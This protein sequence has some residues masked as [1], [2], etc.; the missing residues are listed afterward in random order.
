MK[1]LFFGDIHGIDTNLNVIERKIE[2]EHIDKLVSLGDLYYQGPTP[3]KNYDVNSKKVLEFLNK[4]KDKLI[5]MKGNC[6]SSVDIKVSDFPILDT[7]SLINVDNLDIYIT[8]GDIYNYEKNNFNYKG[9]LVHAHK[10]I[11]YIRQEKDTTYICVGSI[12]LPRE[13]NNPTYA[14]YSNKEITIYDIYD[15]IV[16]K[17]SL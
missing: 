11:P 15:N 7:L 1:I 2:E 6:D 10:H 12:S 14:V 8:H 17:I 4:H 16:N 13:K 5:C 9:V 3:D